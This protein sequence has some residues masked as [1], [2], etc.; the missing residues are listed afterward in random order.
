[1]VLESESNCLKENLILTLFHLVCLKSFEQDSR[2]ELLSHPSR[3]LQSYFYSTWTEGWTPIVLNAE[4]YDI[5]LTLPAVHASCVDPVHL[6][7]ELRMYVTM[8]AYSDVIYNLVDRLF[9]INPPKESYGDSAGNP[10]VFETPPQTILIS[11]W[12][13]HRQDLWCLLTG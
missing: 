11:G 3:N 13:R 9:F 1:M 8:M 12:L 2:S 6:D 4:N 5:T 7:Y 10:L